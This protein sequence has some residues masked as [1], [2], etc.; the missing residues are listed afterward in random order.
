GSEASMSDEFVNLHLHT[1]GSILDSHHTVTQLLDTIKEKGQ[2]ATALT[3]HGSMLN[4]VDF[5]QGAK[6]RGIKPILGMETY[7]TYEGIANK[8]ATKMAKTDTTLAIDSGVLG[9]GHLVLVAKNYTGYQNL[10]RLSS[11]A[12]TDGYYYQ[13]RIDYDLLNKHKEGLVVTTA[14]MFGDFSKMV[15]RGEYDKAEK[16]A[17]RMVDMLGDDFYIELQNHGFEDQI[18]YI[19]KAMEIAKK[20]GANIVVTQDVHYSRPQDYIYQDALFCIG[21]HQK[22]DDPA[23]RKSCQEM[24]VKTRAQMEAMFEGLNVPRIAFDNTM[25][26]M[27]KVEDYTLQPDHFLLPSVLGSHE[28]SIQKLRELCRIGWKAKVAEKIKADPK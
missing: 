10:C 12:H 3:D 16:F 7:V 20:V 25:N 11:I 2:P 15:K 13:P 5:Y 14:C 4:I 1:D 22:W 23:R 9:I 17:G 26:I 8:E 28:A 24:Y 6:E 27:H 18:K 21:K 19:P